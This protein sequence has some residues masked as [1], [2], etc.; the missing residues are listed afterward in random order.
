MT[1]YVYSVMLDSFIKR[2]DGSRNVISET[3]KKDTQEWMQ[4]NGVTHLA[5][6]PVKEAT[7]DRHERSQK[8]L[9]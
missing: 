1:Y 8:I 6:I 7:D 2:D 5:F 9:K 3:V 4:T